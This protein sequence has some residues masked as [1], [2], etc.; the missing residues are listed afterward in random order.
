MSELMLADRFQ[1]SAEE[2][3]D[4]GKNPEDGPYKDQPLMHDRWLTF[5]FNRLEAKYLERMAA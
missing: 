2:F 4:M 1:Q 3:A 5:Y